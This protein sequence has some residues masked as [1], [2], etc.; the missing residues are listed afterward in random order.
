MRAP[1]GILLAVFLPIALT[2]QAAFATELA[3]HEDGWYRWEVPA[4]GGGQSACC[5]RFRGGRASG[6]GCNLG[7][8]TP[9]S[10]IP[11]DCD[12]RS[13]SMH[14]YVEVRGGQVRGIHPFSSA[15]PVDT[16]AEVQDLAGVTTARSIEWLL[17]QAADNPAVLEEALMAI[18]FHAEQAAL[19]ALSG[20]LED[21]NQARS[22]REQALFWLVQSDSDPAY[23][24]LDRLLSPAS[25]N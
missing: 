24:Y 21:R 23:A 9:A 13:D 20:V 10:R 7:A 6:V 25:S 8:G 15:C 1:C 14:I 12:F 4:S 11:P 17:R 5:Y 18:S 22:A 19:A 2:A 3:M 16:G